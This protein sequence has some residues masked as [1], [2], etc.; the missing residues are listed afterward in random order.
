[1]KIALVLNDDFSMYHFRGGL[2]RELVRRNIQVVVIVPPGEFRGKL[3]ELG[4]RCIPI[5]MHRFISPIKDILLTVRLYKVFRA[6]NFDIVHNMTVK[7]NIY[8]TFA[9]SLAG[10]ERRVCLVSGGGFALMDDAS[11][12]ASL[13]RFAVLWMYKLAM[14]LSDKIWFQN[15]DDY[16]L[17][18]QK[19]ITNKRKGVVIRS[20]GINIDEYS[21]ASVDSDTLKNLRDELSLPPSA[22]CVL[23]VAAR[24][25]WSKGVREFVEAASGLHK[26]YP[27]WYFVMVCPEDQGSPDSVPTKYLEGQ[28]LER[29][30]VIDTFRHDIKSFVALA[31]IMVLPSFYPEGVPRTL[32]EGLAM[33]KP[34]VTTDN[35]G[36]REAVENGKNGYLIPIKNSD[37][38]T[39]KLDILMADQDIRAQFGRESRR[40]AENEFSESMVVGRVIREIYE[41]PSLKGTSSAR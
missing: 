41:L 20:G 13:M 19:G 22:N 5:P 15:P 36:C 32:L 26:K 38:L 30:I 33:A 11:W 9:A 34:I 18:V 12:K 17:F 7:P 31:D 14:S 39:K 35:Q 27:N 24:L 29:L 10:I 37:M 2:I 40:K 1:M 16:L 3:E 21:A 6:E 4:I 25:T 8:G 23:M 28:R